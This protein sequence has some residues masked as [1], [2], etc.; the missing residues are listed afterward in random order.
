VGGHLLRQAHELQRAK[1]QLLHPLL[2]AAPEAELRAAVVE[3]RTLV[4]RPELD[5]LLRYTVLPQVGFPPLSL[6]RVWFLAVRR[7]SVPYIPTLNLW[8]WPPLTGRDA[9]GSSQTCNCVSWRRRWQR[10]A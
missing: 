8:V 6:H 7:A 4:A 2:T 3:L 10:G 1:R 9:V 5:Q